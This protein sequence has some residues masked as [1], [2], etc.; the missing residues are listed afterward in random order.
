MRTE[1]FTLFGIVFRLHTS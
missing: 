1:A